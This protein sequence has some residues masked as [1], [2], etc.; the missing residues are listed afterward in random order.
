MKVYWLNIT[1]SYL[2]CIFFN[3]AYRIA[4]YL[5]MECLKN[6]KFCPIHC[7]FY[8]PGMRYLIR[9]LNLND[10]LTQLIT[11]GKGGYVFCS[12]CLLVFLSVYLQSTLLKTL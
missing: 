2:L 3:N 7:S 6:E 10:T 5:M 11:S 12:V 4:Q 1:D 8:L 9:L